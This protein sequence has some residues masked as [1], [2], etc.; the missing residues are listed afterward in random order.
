MMLNN[1][2]LL[3]REIGGKWVADG[4][5]ESKHCL[6]KEI[7]RSIHVKFYADRE[8]RLSSLPSSSESMKARTSLLK[9]NLQKAVRLGLVDLAVMTT[10][11]LIRDDPVQ[12]VRRLPIILLEDKYGSYESFHDHLAT[13]LF[14]LGTNR[15]FDNYQQFLADFVATLTMGRYQP[16]GHL[17]E[18]NCQGGPTHVN[19]LLLRQAYGGMRGDMRMLAWMVEREVLQPYRPSPK[20]VH[21]NASSKRGLELTVLPSAADFHVCPGMIGGLVAQTGLAE[22]KVKSAI[23]LHSSSLRSDWPESEE[24][25][26]EWEA[27]KQAVLSYQKRYIT[28]LGLVNHLSL[29]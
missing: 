14:V 2:L 21:W 8:V 24:L 15:V 11:A 10:L 26:E 3:T 17:E 29:S 28:K 22:E 20:L 18:T 4:D 23:W 25:L 9:S 19:N 12:L 6:I 7:K 13:L 1:N 16:V 27:I 5:I